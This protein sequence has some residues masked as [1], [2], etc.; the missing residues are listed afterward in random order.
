MLTIQLELPLQIGIIQIR[1]L[2]IRQDEESFRQL[3]NCA[4]K[5]Y[6][7]YNDTPISE[8]PGVQEARKLFRLLGIEPTKYRPAS[9]ALLRRAIKQK[10]FS[11]VNNLVDVSNW[12]A[13]DFLLPN[14]AYDIQKLEPPIK[15]RQGLAD[16]SYL[17]LTNQPVHLEKRY[18][19]ADRKGAFGSPKTDSRHS[20]VNS[21]TTE[22]LIVQ[23][24]TTDFDT[25]RLEEL[26][27]QFS[28][29]IL[30]YCGGEIIGMEISSPK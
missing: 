3:L 4:E 11:S 8:V 24:A 28:K 1:S 10:P 12:C 15:L 14:G 7:R 18:C 26:T 19:L 29:R 16:E 25:R 27:K 17:G 22:A 20:A 13:L 9:E 2:K 5:Y 23:Y 21:A 6:N 30:E